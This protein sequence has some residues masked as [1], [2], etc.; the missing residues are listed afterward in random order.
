MAARYE[1]R[2]VNAPEYRRLSSGF[3]VLEDG[4]PI[5][6]RDKSGRLNG[7]W[8]C[9]SG[10]GQAEEWAQETA[11]GRSGEP[12]RGARPDGTPGAQSTR[13]G[14]ISSLFLPAYPVTM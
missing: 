14:T 9:A 5:C 1:D 2:A 7:R 11:Q 6:V 13:N 3:R 10:P 8:D 4:K 12:A